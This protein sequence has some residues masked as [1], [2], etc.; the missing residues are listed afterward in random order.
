MST[1]QGRIRASIAEPAA[2]AVKLSVPIHS[3]ENDGNPQ[4]RA[5]VPIVSSRLEVSLY[6]ADGVPP[7]LN[8]L[9]RVLKPKCSQKKPK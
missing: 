7:I 9:L 4:A 1:R 8:E 3:T 6:P 2:K 5:K